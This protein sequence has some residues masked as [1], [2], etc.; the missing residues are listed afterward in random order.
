S[1]IYATETSDIYTFTWSPDGKFIAVSHYEDVVHIIELETGEVRPLQSSPIA[2]R[3][4]VWSPNGQYLATTTFDIYPGELTVIDIARDKMIFSSKNIAMRGVYYTSVS[5]SPDSTRLAVAYEFGTGSSAQAVFSIWDVSRGEMVSS[6]EDVPAYAVDWNPTSSVIVATHHPYSD[7]VYLVDPDTATI[8]L[9]IPIEQVF[10]AKW[11]KD[12]RYLALYRTP[13]MGSDFLRTEVQIWDP[14][15]QQVIA[16]YGLEFP[17]ESIDDFQW[18]PVD[19]QLTMTV[20]HMKESRFELVLWDWMNDGEVQVLVDNIN[21]CRN[22]AWKP[23]SPIVA[24]LDEN[25]VLK[26]NSID[27]IECLA[28]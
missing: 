19:N 1:G 26:V 16:S 12:G 9:N 13:N 17:Y 8:A 6:N 20:F 22:M 28:K 21:S 7:R 15:S 4:L 11:S 18:Y 5:W 27:A 3:E 10:D 23:D 2:A 14:V 24:Y 25:N